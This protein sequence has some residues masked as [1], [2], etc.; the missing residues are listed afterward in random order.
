MNYELMNNNKV[1]LCGT[2]AKEGVL[3]HSYFGENFYEYQFSVPRLSQSYDLIPVIISERIINNTK[4]TIGSKVSVVGQYR[5]FNKLENGKS[6]LMLSVFARD[7]VENDDT[8]NPNQVILNGYVCKGPVYR[9]TPFKREICD[10]LIAV[11]RAYNKS[12]Y[13]PCIA[14]G[15]NARYVNNFK[16]GDKIE[17]VGRIQSRDYQKKTEDEN[18]ETKTAYEISITRINIEEE[19]EKES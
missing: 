5:S 15:R 8:Q 3:S 12:D 19:K 7:I 17:I 9:T 13:I 11:N 2:I 6:K 1:Y 18:F 4:L 16:V 14:W 10:V